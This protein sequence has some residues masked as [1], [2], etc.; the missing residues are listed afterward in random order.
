MKNLKPTMRE[1]KR[2]LLLKGTNLIENV[3]KTILDYIGILGM[4]KAGLE[5]IKKDNTEAIIAVNRQSLNHVR[6]SFALA[7]TQIQTIRVS[8]TLK[9]LKK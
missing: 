4:A 1:K 3:E 5:W 8:G 2:Y 6:A 9:G 7:D